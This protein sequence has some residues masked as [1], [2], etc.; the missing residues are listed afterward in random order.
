MARR[1]KVIT[2]GFSAISWIEHYLVHG[3]GDVEGE[4]VELDDEFAAFI[5]KAYRLNTTGTRAVRRAAISRP[6]GRAKSELAAFVACFEALGPARFSHFAKKGEVSPWGYAYAVG[7]PVGTPVKRPAISC[8]ATEV[9]Q[10][11]NTYDAIRY[12]L[13]PETCSENLTADY[14]KI[15][16]GITRIL[17]P[18]GGTI[19]PETAKDSSKDGGKETFVVFDETHLW[20]LP[21][22][23]RLH[24][25]VIRNLLKRKVA[26]GWAMETTTMFSPGANS[27]A[28]DTAAFARSLAE[29]G[30]AN[31]RFVF[32]HKQASAKWDVTKKADRL[33]GLKEVY[34]PA[35]AWMD[36]E[37]ICDSYDEP[38]TSEAEWQRYWW[39]RPVSIQGTFV[40]DRAYAECHIARPI[41]DHADVVLA[42][43]GSYNGDSTGIIAVE[44]GEFPHTV[45]GGLWE[46]DENDPDWKI[47]YQ[48]VED[49][50][51]TL[52]KRWRV[53]EITAD[54]YRWA[55]S[56][57]VLAEEGLPVVE[58]PQ[59]SVRMSPATKRL[60]D[61]INTRT[62]SHDGDL[63]LARHVS[64][65]VL[66]ED[67]R[68]ERLAKESKTSTKRIDLAVCWAMALDR[69]VNYAPEPV[70]SD[71]FIL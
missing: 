33:A 26:S 23:K 8:F 53:V 14:G 15:D 20:V 13:D 18:Q 28:E 63:R 58:F 64:N 10:A 40:S 43:D 6:K 71:F 55:R 34:G 41:P 2:L 66:K 22:I 46:K 51:R 7:E 30:T 49:H 52:C 68:G 21:T 31:A 39:N 1:A 19:E 11:G 4:P 69:A 42:L 27:V 61:M 29:K 17:L 16:A 44:L 12:M 36:L 48:D 38:Q 56:L 35:A 37:A 24:Q 65:A 9:G 57:E 3:P 47:N 45:V 59:S 50:I 62:V 67:A 32:D 5:I 54:P 25:V 70:A 60:K